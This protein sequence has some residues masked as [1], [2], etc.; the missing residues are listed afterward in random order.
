MI[1]ARCG[2]ASSTGWHEL[3]Q[4]SAASDQGA[5]WRAFVLSLI[6]LFGPGECGPIHLGVNIMDHDIERQLRLLE[7]RINLASACDR[8]SLYPEVQ[9]MVDGISACGRKVPMRLARIN[10]RLADEVFDDRI[11]NMPC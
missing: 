2:W 1:Y 3:A 9:K 5:T 8:L 11:D 6:C 7:E 4:I 10:A